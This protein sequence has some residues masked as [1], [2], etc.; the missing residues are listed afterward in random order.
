MTKLLCSENPLVKITEADIEG[1]PGRAFFALKEKRFEL[2][3]LSL[4]VKQYRDWLSQG[5][6]PPTL[7]IDKNTNKKIRLS[8]YEAIWIMLIAD[9]RTL[10]VRYTPHLKFFKEN[11]WR[12]TEA[13]FPKEWLLAYQRFKYPGNSDLQTIIEKTKTADIKELAKDIPGF[14]VYGF[15][16][17][18]FQDLFERLSTRFFIRSDKAIGIITTKDKEQALPPYDYSANYKAKFTDEVFVEIPLMRY[19]RRL[20]EDEKLV[21]R[22]RVTEFL[23]KDEGELLQVIRNGNIKTLEIRFDKEQKKPLAYQIEKDRALSRD[24]FDA[25]L[26]T[27]LLKDYQQINF[28]AIKGGGAYYTR[29][30]LKQFSQ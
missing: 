20:I 21:A 4:D 23:S 22:Q 17:R 3:D 13:S 26:N 27:V 12:E 11:G 15:E 1:H 5:V 6:L 2:K 19:I 7:E 28:K 16:Y 8:Y 30:I 14:K 18:V 25:V 24:E 9:L 10:G 29:K